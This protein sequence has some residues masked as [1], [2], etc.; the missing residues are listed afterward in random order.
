MRRASPL[1]ATAAATGLALVSAGAVALAASGNGVHAASA[2][3]LPGAQP[4]AADTRL[5]TSASVIAQARSLTRAA[6]TA[7][8][9]TA[10]MTGTQFLQRYG[11]GRNTSINESRRVW[12]VTVQT[13][14]RTDG[15]PARP[16]KLFDHVSFVIDAETG[17][18]TDECTG[19]GWVRVS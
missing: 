12:I 8:A 9:A 13:P 7:P 16:G 1:I 10:L 3:R 4:S 15:G 14:M 18:V 11:V 6:A 17:T 19:C 5:A 2:H